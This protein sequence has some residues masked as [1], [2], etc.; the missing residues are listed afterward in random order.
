[1]TTT[2][3]RWLLL[4]VIAVALVLAATTSANA[5]FSAQSSVALPAVSTL[6]VAPPTGLT[7]GASSCYWTHDPSTGWHYMAQT[8]ISWTATTT[9]RG[10]TGYVVTALRTDGSTLTSLAVDPTVTSVTGT[11]DSALYVRVTVTTTTSYGWTAQTA[12]SQAITC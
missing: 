10:V 6:Q 12:P 1:M 2:I 11:F 3:R 4:P 5:A 8:K 7:I 9:T